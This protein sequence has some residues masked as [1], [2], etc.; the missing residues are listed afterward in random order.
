M[1][2]VL[3]VEDDPVMIRGLEDN[4]RMT[5]TTCSPRAT[6]LRVGN[7]VE[8]AADLVILDFMLLESTAMKSARASGKGLD[9]PYLC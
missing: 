2:T 8:G 6:V 4:F 1:A 5:V 3:I 7:D 9:M